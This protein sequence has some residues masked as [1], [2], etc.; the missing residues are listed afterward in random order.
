MNVSKRGLSVSVVRT[1]AKVTK[2]NLCALGDNRL[3]LDQLEHFA[4]QHIPIVQAHSIEQTTR[5]VVAA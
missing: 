2:H 1:G 3:Q 4:F 5:A